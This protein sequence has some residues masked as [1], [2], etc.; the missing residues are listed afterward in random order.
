[1]NIPQSRVKFQKGPHCV[2]VSTKRLFRFF[3]EVLPLIKVPM[4][5]NFRL[6]FY[7]KILKT[8]ILWFVILE[9]GIRTSAYEFF[10]QFQSWP[11]RVKMCD[12]PR[13]VKI[14]I[15]YT[16]GTVLLT[17]Y[18]RKTKSEE[19]IFIDF[20]YKG[21]TAKRRMCPCCFLTTA[22]AVPQSPN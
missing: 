6:L 12:I 11:I 7:S 5:W 1:M 2:L 3:Q 22:T 19:H 21:P 9:F 16:E 10:L 14:C 8:M 4:K 15:L 17:L 18:F 13:A 20:G